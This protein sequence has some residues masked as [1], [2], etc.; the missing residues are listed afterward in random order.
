MSATVTDVS[1]LYLVDAHA[2]LHRAYHALPPLKSSKGEPVGALYGFARMLLSIIRRDKPQYLAVCFDSPGPT[3]R[4]KAYAEYKATR[5]EIDEDLKVQL[6]LARE[7][8]EA[9]GLRCV[10]ASGFEA[11][12]LM[13]T[14]ARRG[15]QKGLD[16]IL[17]TGDKD[18]LQMVN[19]RIQVLNE[20]KGEIFDDRKV[21]EKFKVPPERIADYLALIGDSSDNVPGVP[22]IGPVGA[23][24]LLNRYGSLDEI[25]KAVAGGDPDIPAKTLNSFREN[26][27]QLRLSRKLVELDAAV[28]LEIDLKEC[29]NPALDSIRALPMFRRFDFNTLIREA[30]GKPAASAQP[31]HGAAN[32]AGAAE[33]PAV[34]TT[35]EPEKLPQPMTL[36]TWLKAAGS[37]GHV[38][39]ALRSVDE[40]SRSGALELPLGQ[41][42]WIVA[43]T[44]SDG[45]AAVVSSEEIASSKE[46]LVKLLA[47]PEIVKIGHDLKTIMKAL[48]ASSLPVK[49]PRFDTMLA[50]Y[51]LNPSRSKYD[52]SVIYSDLV[53]FTETPE[54]EP[55]QS[56]LRESLRLWELTAVL[57]RSLKEAGVEKL[58][59]TLELPLIDV[60]AE[61]EKEGIGLDRRYMEDLGSEFKDRI[62]SM[63]KEIGAMAGGEINLNS[64]K[65][66]RKLLFEDLK[67]PVVHKTP[68]GEPSTDEEALVAL[69]QHHPLPAKIIDYRELT[70]LESTYV[71]GLLAKIDPRTGRVHTRF[72]Q[73]GTATGRLSSLEPNLQNI[74]IRT[75]LGQKIRRAFVPK[76]GCV[77]VSADYSQIDLRV[78]AHLSEDPSLCEAFRNGEDV[79]L[80]TACE[81]FD[82]PPEKVDSELRRRAKA[83]NFGIVYGL[84]A[85]GLGQGLGIPFN[86]AREYIEKYFARYH[87]VAKWIEK[88]L[89]A[90]RRDGCVRTILGRVRLLPDLAAKNTQVRQFNERAA[91]NTP[92]QGSSADIIK[93]AMVNIHRKMAERPRQW[94]SRPVLQVHDELLFECPRAEAEEF[95]RWA[96]REM[97]SAVPLR[98]P[99][100][101]DLKMGDNWQDMKPLDKKP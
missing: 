10:E 22:G 7:M 94:R 39:A 20:A 28:P 13:A 11:D 35:S 49:P 12:D 61:M 19:K 63:E 1:R 65:Q 60:L 81:I 40:E 52:F 56:A 24:K 8:V 79:H 14:L 55:G 64:T 99:L 50:A 83:V 59:E 91:A 2:Y 6:A 37:A 71:E 9:M 38:A 87:G 54:E 33:S 78:L 27:P 58:Y 96:R 80:R 47:D 88:N 74:P 57:K 85:H 68:K 25:L 82:V 32:G 17:V 76:T 29:Q 42:R 70:K 97:E 43:L 3:F 21:E 26:E 75:P 62:L 77:F 84:T 86:A 93:Q 69:S 23:V 46:A 100:V 4:H 34:S 30:G 41:S 51:C 90:A 36:K 67:L 92:I 45:R 15:E 31:A 89:E 72:D 73:A 18:A 98:I 48:D 44:L 16:V 101:V 66:M 53:Q 5:K 95:G